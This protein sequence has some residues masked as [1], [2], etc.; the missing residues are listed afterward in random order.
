MSFFTNPGSLAN[1]TLP[2]P[3]LTLVQTPRTY[4]RTPSAYGGTPGTYGGTPTMLMQKGT[5]SNFTIRSSKV[6]AAWVSLDDQ[7][8]AITGHWS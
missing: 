6:A 1:A 2:D 5:H 4:V 7:I 8:N 3:D